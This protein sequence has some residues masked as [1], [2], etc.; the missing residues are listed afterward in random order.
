MAIETVARSTNQAINENILVRDIGDRVVQLEPDITPLLVMTTNA[1]RKKAVVTPR[2][3]RIEDQLRSVWGQSSAAADYSSVATGV[4]VVD[5]TLFAIGDLVVPTKAVSSTAAEEQVRVTAITGG[6]LT[7]TRG[8]GGGADTI[9]AT[10]ALRITG[11]A[12]AEGDP[13]GTPRSTDKS[14][15]ISYTQIFRE[16]IKLTKTMLATQIYGDQ[17]QEYQIAKA[18]KE[19]KKQIEAAGLWGRASETLASPGSLRTT[20]G[21]KSRVITN[22]TDGGTTVTLTAFNTFSETAFRY[23]SPAK[24]FIAAPKVISAI[25][26]FSQ[27]KLL[28][29]VGQN[30]FGVNIKRLTLPHGELLLARNWLMERGIAATNGFE[31]EAYCVDLDVAEYRF[32]SANGVSRDTALYRDIIKS[33]IDAVTHEVLTEAGWMYIQ[34]KRHARMFNVVAYA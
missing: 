11:S 34:E 7:V 12:Y 20:M 33:G 1:K 3:E 22:V 15:V 2:I 6:T 9:A 28:T 13:V 17:D 18:L 19:H 24:L 4:F 21:F 29:E 32:L 16:P 14:V 25:N 30:V 10:G 27:N 23:G 26:F 5:A 31:D 8:L